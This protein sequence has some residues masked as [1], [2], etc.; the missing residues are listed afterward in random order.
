MQDRQFHIE[1]TTDSR[2]SPSAGVILPL[3]RL[4][5]PPKGRQRLA[6]QSSVLS[7]G[8]EPSSRERELPMLKGLA[9]SLIGLSSIVALSRPT[10]ADPNT[11]AERVL[12]AQA[13]PSYIPWYTPPGSPWPS[14][15]WPA[16]IPSAYAA[17]DGA[18]AAGIVYDTGSG[19]TGSHSGFDTF[20]TNQCNFICFGQPGTTSSNVF[21]YGNNFNG[22]ALTE[23]GAPDD[24]GSQCPGGIVNNVFGIT[25]NPQPPP[26]NSGSF[27]S[28][29]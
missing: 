16:P 26:V 4:A 14:P 15:T 7:A 20:M 25:V 23:I 6:G 1:T 29:R 21:V 13:A 19:G 5:P 11:A 10:V 22:T 2:R 27:L 28:L 9:I 3:Q 24:C 18:F 17:I 8:L 12:I